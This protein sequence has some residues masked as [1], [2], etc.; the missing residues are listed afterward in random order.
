VNLRDKLM[1]GGSFGVPVLHYKREGEFLEADATTNPNNHFNYAMFNETLTTSGV[2]LNLKAGLI[3]KP[4]EFWRIGLAFHSPSLYTLTDSYEASITADVENGQ[5]ST[6]YSKDY[7]NNEPSQF[8][9][10]YVTPYKVIG[11]I[12]YVIREI[13]DVTKQRGF[14]TADVE[15]VNYKASSFSTDNG[16]SADESTKNYLKQLNNAI[17]NAYKGA[18]NLRVGGELKFTTLMVRLGG[19][20]YG[21]PY[22]NIHGEKGSKL[23]L[24]GGLGYR[25]KGFFVDLTYIY[26]INKD[27]NYAYRLANAPYFGANLKNM[28]SNVLLTIGFKI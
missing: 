28:A 5:P 6:D 19:A 9:Y 13:E 15:Y 1:L 23:D 2:G 21:N 26:G 18:F 20:Y 12:S 27:V 14:L 7:T 17:D 11:S 10:T 25:N 22:K 3:Y 4:A 24:S 8:K 16:T